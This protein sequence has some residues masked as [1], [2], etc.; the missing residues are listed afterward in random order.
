MGQRVQFHAPIQDSSIRLASRI[1]A[2]GILKAGGV[3]TAVVQ[4]A[5]ACGSVCT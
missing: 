2:L 1:T 3:V 5:V 4:V